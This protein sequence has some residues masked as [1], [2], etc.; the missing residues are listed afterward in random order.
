MNTPFASSEIADQAAKL[1]D[2]SPDQQIA[3]IV[4]VGQD[5]EIRIDF[6][7]AWEPE[8]AG[9]YRDKFGFTVSCLLKQL[10]RREDAEFGGGTRSNAGMVC[11][12]VDERLC[13]CRPILVAIGV[14]VDLNNGAERKQP[15]D[16]RTV[17]DFGPSPQ[18]KRQEFY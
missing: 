9:E 15:I 8:H 7:S 12:C 10:S 4:Q 5:A 2:V 1:Q 11:A 17:V 14:D 3:R 18:I 13:A 6:S 16:G